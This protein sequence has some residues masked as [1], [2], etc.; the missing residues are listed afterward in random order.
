MRASSYCVGLGV[1]KLFRLD[2][3]RVC[4]GII[5]GW[6]MDYYSINVQTRDR[7]SFSILLLWVTEKDE[8]NHRIVYLH[9][10]YIRFATTK[11]GG[12]M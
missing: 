7:I 12:H 5:V 11:A 3:N 6:R 8:E 4:V 9:N 2:K 1:G 10:L